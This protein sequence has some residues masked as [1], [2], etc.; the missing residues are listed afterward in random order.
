MSPPASSG[1][2]ERSRVRDFPHVA[3][4]NAARTAQRAVPAILI[5]PDT[6]NLITPQLP[7]L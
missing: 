6:F 5:V 4:L 3:P 7:A 2:N 1:R